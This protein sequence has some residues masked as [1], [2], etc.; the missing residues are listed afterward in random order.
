MKITSWTNAFGTI[1]AI[2]TTISAFMVSMGCV[3]GAVDFA[4]TCNIPFLPPSLVAIAGGA[5]GLLTFIIKLA[6]PG[7]ILHSLF[8]GTAVIVPLADSG[9]GTVTQGQVNSNG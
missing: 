3:P 4:A 6:R 7:G 2:L 9:V 8:G 1:T 5:F